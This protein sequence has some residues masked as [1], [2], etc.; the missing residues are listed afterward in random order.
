[1]LGLGELPKILR[2]PFNIFSTA[3]ATYFNFGTQFGFAKT[4]H[5]IIPRGNVDAALG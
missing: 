3:E 1:M 4:H 2:F 5:K